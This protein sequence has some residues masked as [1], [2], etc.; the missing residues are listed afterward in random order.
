MVMLTA[1]LGEM[2]RVLAVNSSPRVGTVSKTEIMLDSL[3]E[4]MREKG[5]HVDVVNL[6]KKKI[7]YCV[8]CFT[9]WTKTPGKCAQK[10]DMAEELFPMYSECDLCV[11]ATPLYH[12]TLNAQM[13]AFIERTLPIV[14]PFFVE[15][16][17]VT[18]H[19]LR[20]PLPSTVVLSGAGFPED[21][22]FDQ[23]RSYV[24]FLFGE[25]L[26][27][28]IYRPAAEMLARAGSNAAAADVL[29]ALTQAGG[30]LVESGRVEAD[31][32]R[33]IE[34]P[35]TDFA[36]MAPLTNLAWRTCID[37][38]I[39]LGEFR[40]KRV[41]LR[42]DSI[43]SFL[44]LL[45]YGFKSKSAADVSAKIQYRFSGDV[46]GDCYVAV[47]S[48]KLSCGLGTADNAD[49][50]IE[51]PFDVWM[52]ILTGEADGPALL[53][54]GKYRVSGDMMLMGRLRGLFR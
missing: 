17:G 16:N 20:Q 11:L 49:V 21:S 44:G 48:G 2:M 26:V 1:N 42:P 12:Y 36:G 53:A 23:L 50:M 25:S 10:D 19:P 13:K 28:E 32:L 24:R 22:V 43:E 52:D 41:R 35:L 3:A 38:G 6:H 5:A 39:T 46:E 54:E 33:R 47:E 30:E 14:E 45:Q 31:T 8:G 18:T 51:A 34:Q 37:R 27:A 40:K 7:N 9:C 29:A 15:K 4:G